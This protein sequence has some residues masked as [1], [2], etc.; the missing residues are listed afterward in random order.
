MQ[1]VGVW[2]RKWRRVSGY[3][4]LSLDRL[5]SRWE[6][7]TGN[8]DVCLVTRH[9]VWTDRAVGGSVEQEMKTCVSNYTMLCLDRPCRAVGE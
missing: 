9:L 8:E 4:T 3:T 1:S 2:N 6:S 5:C 7:G